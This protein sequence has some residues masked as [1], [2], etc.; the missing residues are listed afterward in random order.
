MSALR[1]LKRQI[2]RYEPC[3]PRPAKAPPAGPGQIHEIK[4]DGFRILAE[5]HAG[6]VRLITRKGFDLADHFPLAVAAIAALPARSCVVDGE[7]IAVDRPGAL[8]VRPDSATATATMPLR[9][10]PRPLR[11]G[12]RRPSPGTDR[13]PQTHPQPGSCA[14]SIAVSPSTVISMVKERSSPARLRARL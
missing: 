6:G 3:L 9:F 10:A 4:H 1:E 7:A 5:L 11:A 12:R 8:G 2:R 14:M 13:G